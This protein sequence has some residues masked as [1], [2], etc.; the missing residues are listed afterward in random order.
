MY[1]LSV[2][3]KKDLSNIIKYSID[4][5]GTVQ[6]DK[7]L[8]QLKSALEKLVDFPLMGRNL[9]Y[10]RA[11]LYC[12]TVQSHIIFYQKRKQDIFVVRILHKKMDPQRYL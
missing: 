7:Y 3:A 10:L 8:F 2:K 6:T 4:E 9:S 5:F 1:K 12:Y 11:N